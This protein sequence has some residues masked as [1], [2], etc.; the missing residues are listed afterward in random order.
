MRGNEELS[1]AQA[2][3]AC[4]A[5][6]YSHEGVRVL[7]GEALHPGGLALTAR[8]AE[9]L[10]L[11]REDRVLD[12]AAGV[13]ATACYLGRIVQCRVEG[14]DLS[15]ANLQRARQSSEE[16][17]LDGPVHF[18]AGDAEALPYRDYVFDAVVS[19]CAFSTF[20]GKVCAAKEIFRVLRPGGHVGLAD[21]T[22]EPGAL[23]DELRG[24]L[25]RAA[26]LADAGT[27]DG[28][29]K[30]FFEAGFKGF[31]VEDHSQALVTLLGKV[32]ARLQL[33]RLASRAGVVSVGRL[34]LD[35]VERVV[36]QVED[37][38]RNGRVGYVLLVTKRP[39]ET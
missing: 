22:V 24:I 20:P 32:R 13:G 3:K 30:S 33:G 36:D 37:M 14:L 17:G 10:E 34:D 29:Q 27:V 1:H 19:E 26:C 4:C 11:K 31:R 21:V 15:T 8:L 9:L 23:S 39:N 6:L 18:L 12:V 28:Y 16:A 25:S 38:V 2:T 35:A 5:E 7:L